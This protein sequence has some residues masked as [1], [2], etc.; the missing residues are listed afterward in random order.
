M[1]GSQSPPPQADNT[2]E[3]ITLP[4][5]SFAGGKN[6]LKVYTSRVLFEAFI[7]GS[8]DFTNYL[9]NG[10]SPILYITVYLFNLRLRVAMRLIFGVQFG[11]LEY[12]IGGR[13]L[14][15]LFTKNRTDSYT[16]DRSGQCCNRIAAPFSM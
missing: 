5:T 10:Q 16:R 13:I 12:Y 7:C 11:Y 8:A 2:C 9:Y 3:N 15:D 6:D 4:E 14:V 1:L